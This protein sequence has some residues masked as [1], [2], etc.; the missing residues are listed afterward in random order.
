MR[1][2]VEGPTHSLSGLDEGAEGRHKATTA[3]IVEQDCHQPS[4]ET[5]EPSVCVCGCVV[6]GVWCVGGGGVG[7]CV[8]VVCVWCVCGVVCLW[9][10]SSVGVSE[11]KDDIGG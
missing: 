7:V 10:G 2:E 4:S 3:I 8:C 9:C 1:R 11:R 6:C 5:R